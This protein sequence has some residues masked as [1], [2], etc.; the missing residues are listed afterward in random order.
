MHFTF[1][2]PQTSISNL[3]LGQGLFDY[4]VLMLSNAPAEIFLLFRIL[5]NAWK[6]GEGLGY[7]SGKMM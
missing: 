5:R 2:M 7:S 4:Q 6:G 1:V 3:R